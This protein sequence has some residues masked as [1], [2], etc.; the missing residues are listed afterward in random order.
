M[1]R[2]GKQPI[3]VPRGVEVTIDGSQRHGEGPE[4][5]ARA[6]ASPADDH[7][8]ARRRRRS[9]STRPDDERAAPRAARPDPLAGRQ[10]GHRR[11]RGLHQGARDRRRRLPR[12]R[13]GPAEDRARR[14]ATRTRCTVDA[15]EGVTFEVP[16]ADPHHGARASTSSSSARWRPTSARS[17]SPS[18]TRARASATPTSA[19]CA[20]PASRRSRDRR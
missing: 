4:G 14:S 3:T 19:C 8:H 16:A 13:A 9:W 5:H 2:I 6:R 12:R 10:H 1:S 18:P 15:P 17:A 11:V 7:R 20:R